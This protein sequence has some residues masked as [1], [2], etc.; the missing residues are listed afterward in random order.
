[1]EDLYALIAEAIEELEL[2][3]KNEDPN[4]IVYPETVATSRYRGFPRLARSITEPLDA[5]RD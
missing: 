5:D 3:D 2:G 1:M 4:R